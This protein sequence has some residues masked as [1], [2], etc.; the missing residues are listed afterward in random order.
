MNKKPNASDQA[1]S[2][3]AG[4]DREIEEAIEKIAATPGG[5]ELFARIGTELSKGE[6]KLL[7]A[8]M[9]QTDTYALAYELDIE[10]Q[11]VHNCLFTIQQKL[12]FESRTELLRE[13]LS[14]I[15]KKLRN[16]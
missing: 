8:F 11:S 16:S 14:A 5:D 6:R 13:V 1:A 15:V 7:W 10:N 12:G 2:V 9:L 3:A 4:F